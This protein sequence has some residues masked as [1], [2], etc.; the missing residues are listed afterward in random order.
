MKAHVCTAALLLAS[1]LAAPTVQAQQLLE[2]IA[3]DDIQIVQD[4]EPAMQKAFVLARQSLDTFLQL[5]KQPPQG[6]DG[7]A[8]KV[9][10]RDGHARE[11][12]WVIDFTQ[13]DNDF[14]GTL[15]NTPRV[16][17]N[18]RGGQTYSFAKSDIVDWMY[19]DAQGRMQG[20]LTMCA[21]LTKEPAAEAA[22]V[23]TQYQITCPT[24]P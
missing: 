12:F 16:V 21:L 8:V 7:F 20:N 24:L 6:S 14:T 22:A 10:V 4:A 18:V 13:Q 17:R 23:R 15:A 11:F 2:K 1:M 19:I 9:G 3:Q 5:V